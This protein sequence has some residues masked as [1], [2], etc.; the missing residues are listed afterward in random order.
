M[1]VVTINTKQSSFPIN[2]SKHGVEQQHVVSVVM[3]TALYDVLKRPV[4][5]LEPTDP[6]PPGQP[7]STS[8]TAIEWQFDWKVTAVMKRRE[9]QDLHRPLT[10]SYKRPQMIKRL[11]SDKNTSPCLAA[12]KLK[13]LLSARFHSFLSL[14]AHFS[15]KHITFVNYLVYWPLPGFNMKVVSC[16]QS[17]RRRGPQV[18]RPRS[19]VS[20]QLII[21]LSHAVC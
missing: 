20:L 8:T 1:Q 7:P 11:Q 13:D 9:I 17:E 15:A 4:V 5:L 14:S 2:F 21:Y 12:Y 3:T 18:T 6:S 10:R 19:L 16:W